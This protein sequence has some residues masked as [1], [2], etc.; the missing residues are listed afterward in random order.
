LS[1]VVVT[2]L[3]CIKNWHAVLDEKFCRVGCKYFRRGGD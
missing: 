1:A 3:P 2:C